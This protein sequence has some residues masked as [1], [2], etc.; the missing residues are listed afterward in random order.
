MTLRLLHR[1]LAGLLGLFIVTH[2]GAHLFAAAGPKS[3]AGA[4]APLQAVYRN[5]V[6]ETVLIVAF[7]TQIVVGLGLAARRWRAKAMGVWGALQIASGAYIAF[8]IV[9]HFSAA[10]AAR[11]VSHVETNFYWPAG[12]LTLAPLPWFFAPYYALG[13]TSVFVHAAAALK[14]NAKGALARRGPPVLVGAGALLSVVIL[15]IFSG[16]FFEIHLPAEHQR[17]FDGYLRLLGGG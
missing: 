6:G 12:T 1:L 16:A 15:L 7:A 17:Y 10:L 9:L 11:H 4:L 2:L 8:F 3:H 14:F 13:V 5:A